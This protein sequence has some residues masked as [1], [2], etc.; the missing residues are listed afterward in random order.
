M[1]RNKDGYITKG[2]LKLAKKNVGMNEIDQ[3]N[4]NYDVDLNLGVDLDFGVE[5]NF[6]TE[7]NFAVNINQIIC[8]HESHLDSK[9]L[10]IN[11]V[12][13]V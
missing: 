8:I 12:K 7:V 2:E 9:K 5:V 10:N 3:V 1:D 11:A 13:V 6:G 4:L